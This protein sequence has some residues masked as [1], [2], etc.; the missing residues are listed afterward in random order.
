M[1]DFWVIKSTFW[2]YQIMLLGCKT[3]GL[4]LCLFIAVWG[5]RLL[6]G[7]GSKTPHAITLWLGHELETWHCVIKIVFIITDWAFLSS[8][9]YGVA[10]CLSVLK[11]TC[12]EW[13]HMHFVKN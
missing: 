2:S 10:I 9:S 1:S 3:V 4:I 11:E 13:A 7:L 8:N 6:L 12:N 5:K